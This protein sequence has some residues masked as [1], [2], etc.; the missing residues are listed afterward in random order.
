MVIKAVDNLMSSGD[1]VTTPKVQ[2]TR[3]LDFSPNL[4]KDIYWHNMLDV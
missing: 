2:V 3:C 1:M 4:I